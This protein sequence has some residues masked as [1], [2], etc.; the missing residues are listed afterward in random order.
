VI[1]AREV[2][3]FLQAV[4][5]RYARYLNRIEWRFAAIGGFVIK[6]AEYPDLA[7]LQKS[8]GRLHR[9]RDR[10]HDG[11]PVAT[12]Q[13]RADLER[14]RPVYG[15]GNDC[16]RLPWRRQRRRRCAYLLRPPLGI[17]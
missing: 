11:G 16:R 6:N 1:G 10:T 17:A 13:A 9:L 15:W 12:T 7:T 5:M 8:R 14:A 4:R 3:G 2:L